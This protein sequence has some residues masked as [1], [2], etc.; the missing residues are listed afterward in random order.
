MSFDQ[1]WAGLVAN[2]QAQSSPSMNLNDAESPGG[3]GGGTLSVSA[4]VLRTYAGKSDTTRGEFAKADNDTMRETEQVPGTMKGFESDEA[5]SQLQKRWRGQMRYLDQQLAGVSKGLRAAAKDFKAEDVRSKQ[6]MDRLRPPYG[7]Y[8]PGVTRSP[9]G[10]YL[11]NY[12]LPDAGSQ[13]NAPSP[14]PEPP[15]V[16]GP[17]V[18]DTGP[19]PQNP[20][21][22]NPLPQNP[23]LQNPFVPGSN[24]AAAP[25]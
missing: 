11:P 17:F 19:T 4:S 7:P 1:E 13:G 23:L 2:A 5:M 14:S 22:Q 8:A 9:Y 15:P 21:P 12:L 3:G 25:K 20:T 6:E 24:D 16:Y 18:P 10:P